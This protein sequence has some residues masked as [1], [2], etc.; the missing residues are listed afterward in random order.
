MACFVQSVGL[1][2]GATVMDF[3]KS[4][5]VAA[6][7]GLTCMLLGGFY[8]KNIPSWLSWVQYLAY[9]TYA[10]DGALTIEFASSPTF[11]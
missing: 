3:K 7:Y 2:I 11:R 4:I 9:I 6:V 10:Y 8:Q 1:C 5:V